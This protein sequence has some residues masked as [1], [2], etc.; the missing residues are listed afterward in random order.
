M[1]CFYCAEEIQDAAVVCRYC[2]RDLNFLRPFVQKIAE[3]QE[4][5]EHLQS[6]VEA[7]AEREIIAAAAVPV[8]HHPQPNN[9]RIFFAALGSVV[10][11]VAAYLMFNRGF[12]SIWFLASIA[13][14]L[15]WGL[16]A[17]MWSRGRHGRAYLV[18]GVLSGLAVYAI[19]QMI[20][21]T[22][23]PELPWTFDDVDYLA[24]YLLGATLFFTT[25]GLVGDL[26]ERRSHPEIGGS[27]AAEAFAR[28]LIV[29]RGG[30]ASAADAARVKN[31]SE[32]ITALAPVLTFIGSIVTAFLTYSAAMGHK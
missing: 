5:V 22:Q 15:P 28:R 20:W 1:R 4:Q 13:M 26:I 11:S 21:R 18:A 30:N 27:V 2:G 23:H 9:G 31:L 12:G 29:Q 10:A 17:G 24:R 8:E 32:M 3:L 14:P 19:V 25:G 7:L 6:T 16:V